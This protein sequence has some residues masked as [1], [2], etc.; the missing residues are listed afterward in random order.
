MAPMQP[1]ADSNPLADTDGGGSGS[2][3]QLGSSRWRSTSRRPI[4]SG[5]SGSANGESA[6]HVNAG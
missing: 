6:L 5:R 3:K 1:Q 4:V 2:Q